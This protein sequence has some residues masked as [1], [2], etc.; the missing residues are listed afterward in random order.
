VEPD[1]SGDPTERVTEIPFL[2][3]LTL[4]SYPL[5]QLDRK[6]AMAKM[7]SYSLKGGDGK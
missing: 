5:I 2:P 7:Y 3:P 6:W 1:R 4:Q